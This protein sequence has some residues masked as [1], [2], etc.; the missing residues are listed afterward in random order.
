MQAYLGLDLTILTLRTN[1]TNPKSQI[2]NPKKIVMVDFRNVVL[3][4]SEQQ[5]L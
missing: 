2:P 5:G 4:L 3:N 1:F